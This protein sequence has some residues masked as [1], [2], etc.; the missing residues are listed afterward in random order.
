MV[1][2]IVEAISLDW[3]V[4]MGQWDLCEVTVLVCVLTIPF[5]CTSHC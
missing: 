3:R 1:C 2:W 4:A 5:A